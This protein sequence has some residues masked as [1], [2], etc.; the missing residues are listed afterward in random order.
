MSKLATQIIDAVRSRGSNATDLRDAAHEACHAIEYGVRGSWNR[1]AI[2]AA[3]LRT[4]KRS[5]ILGGNVFATA[6]IHARAVEQL[7]GR[8]LGVDVGTVESWAGLATL[9]ALTNS[10][11]RFPS[12]PWLV[13]EIEKAMKTTRV[14][15]I[16]DQILELKVR[17]GTITRART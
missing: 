11:F 10:G 5:S 4:A 17:R 9:E 2:H 7:V 14:R 15:A 16:R 6:E 12:V 1:E 8:K 3:I 13:D